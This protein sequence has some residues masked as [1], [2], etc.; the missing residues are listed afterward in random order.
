MVKSA[1]VVE[2][3][4]SGDRQFLLD[5]NMHPTLETFVVAALKSRPANLYEFMI[6]WAN[7]KLGRDASSGAPKKDEK[8]AEPAKEEAKPAEE[9]KKETT[10]EAV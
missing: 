9:E 3:Q 5:I 6:E 1:A 10:E 4:L 8:K 2:E 7:L